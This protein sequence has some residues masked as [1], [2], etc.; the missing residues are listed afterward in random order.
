M[1]NYKQSIRVTYFD[2]KEKH[3]SFLSLTVPGRILLYLKEVFMKRIKRI[4]FGVLAFLLTFSQ[5]SYAQEDRSFV[6]DFT[7]EEARFISLIEKLEKERKENNI[8]GQ[9]TKKDTII[10]SAGSTNQKIVNI[11]LSSFQSVYVS[12]NDPF[13]PIYI[14]HLSEDRLNHIL[15]N[16]G[17][18]GLGHAFSV[19]EE[20][21]G[22]NSIFL[23]SL[24]SLE[25]AYGNSRIAQDKNNLFGYNANDSNPY[26]DATHFATKEDA[27]YFVA[28][29][30]R[31]NYLS[32]NGIHFNGYTLEGVNVRYCTSPLWA[33]KIKVIM[34][35]Y[36]QKL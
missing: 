33:N 35:K 34:Q 32:P 27:V 25:S 1:C 29:K 15:E 10:D 14:T 30:L 26:H 4:F 17:L 11:P 28:E 20:A 24:A 22:I 9:D 2:F 3:F 8:A 5:I 18:K 6:E 12:Q 13:S 21:Y 36:Y 23:I 31:K 16:T 7:K 19:A